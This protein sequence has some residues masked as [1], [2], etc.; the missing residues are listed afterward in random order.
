[1]KN[2]VRGVKCMD[3]SMPMNSVNCAP[4]PPRRFSRIARTQ[5]E[6]STTHHSAV[7]GSCSDNSL[8]TLHGETHNLR[9]ELMQRTRTTGVRMLYTGHSP[10]INL[11]A[12]HV[13]ER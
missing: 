4:P 13:V 7:Y 6:T 11:R 10:I 5:M 3:S 8:L 9:V 2:L 1:L 12:P